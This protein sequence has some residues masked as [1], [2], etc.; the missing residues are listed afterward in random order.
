MREAMLGGFFGDFFCDTLRI[1]CQVLRR[2]V[3][4]GA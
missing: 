2:P 3:S 1:E 4:C